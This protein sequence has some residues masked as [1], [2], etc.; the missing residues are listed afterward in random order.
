MTTYYVNYATGSDTN[1]GS[2]PNS[3]WK[4]A[5]G[6]SNA[7]GNVKKETLVGGDEVLFKAGVVYQGAITF[8]TS[9]TPGNPIVYEGTGWGTGHA[10]MSGLTSAQLTF[11]AD[12]SNPKLSVATLPAGLIPA[13]MS[14]ETQSALN[15]IVE[16][17]GKVSYM[18]N[19]STSSNP[20]FPDLGATAYS[21]SQ[22]KGSGSS[23]TLTDPSL[24]ASLSTSSASTISNMVARTYI[25]SNNELN[26][27]VTGYNA[28]TGALS[29]SGKF[30]APSNSPS[31]TL[32][33]NPAFVSSSNPYSEYALEG[34][35]IIAAVTPGV[36]TVSVSTAPRAFNAGSK[37][38]ITVDGFDISGYGAGDGRG[39][40]FANAQNIQITNNTLSNLATHDGYGF[41]AISASGITNLTISGNTVGPNITYGAGI[42]DTGGTND[43]VSNNTINAPGWSGIVEFNDINSSV[44]SNRITNAYGVHA[45]GIIAFDVNG[46]QQSQNV[47]ITNNQIE[48]GI[49]GIAI[50]GNPAL[51]GPA[52]TPDNFTIAYNV[53]TGET[54][55]GIADWGKTNT[56]DIYGNIVLTTSTA[57]GALALGT[58]SKNVSIYDNILQGYPYLASTNTADTFSNNVSLRANDPNLPR[59]A[60]ETGNRAN[61][62]LASILQQA[63]ASPG[64]LPASIGSILRPADGPIGIDWSTPGIN[65]ILGAAI[66]DAKSGLSTSAMSQSLPSHFFHSPTLVATSLSVGHGGGNGAR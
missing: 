2:S 7:T 4:H 56:A 55:W 27:S 42:S 44:S 63:L 19:D 32:Y 14:T 62:G 54:A 36:H 16:I 60:G 38:N 33:N 17:D 22:M 51:S 45:T 5:P 11:T 30:V 1:S 6:D 57:Y 31:V 65:V 20:Y 48:N 59:G 10:I 43:I 12:P 21:A 8:Q 26:M 15:N 23:W 18:S 28:T 39:I 24:G 53:I 9:G 61:P 41:G 47:S 29:L 40:V 37:S 66:S 25:I 58:S 49:A 52:A 34:N 35:Q 46:G 50:E 13:G 64:V 3:P